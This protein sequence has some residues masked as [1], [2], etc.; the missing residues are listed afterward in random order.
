MLFTTWGVEGP[1][2]EYVALHSRRQPA[3]I[4]CT[5][6]P[7]PE[8]M[9]PFYRG[10]G[11]SLQDFNIGKDG[12]GT[13]IGRTLLERGGKGQERWYQY[14][15]TDWGESWG[16]PTR[17]KRPRHPLPGVFREAKATKPPQRLLDSLLGS[18]R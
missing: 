6:L 14:R 17:A 13:L 16:K 1:G 4:G 2:G 9:Q 12:R 8:D 3:S 10:V 11:L 7:F 18:V 5:T 15:T